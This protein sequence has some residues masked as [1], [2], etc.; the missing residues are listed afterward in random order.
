MNAAPSPA[1]APELPAPAVAI[2][3]P[4]PRRRWKTMLLFAAVFVAGLVCGG[5]AAAVAVLHAIHNGLRHP[6]LRVERAV[7]GLS[8]RLDLDHAQQARV[9]EILR[10]QNRELQG[11]RR[12]VWPRVQTRL[13]RTEDEI[14]RE[15]TPDQR[16][17]WERL[18][19]GLRR[20]WFPPGATGAE[21]PSKN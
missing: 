17:K 8:R 12:E 10:D 20:S 15:L 5:A 16:R 19:A 18:A 9:R 13:D 3:V 7:R 2:P 11:L 21:P 14:G 4:P 6:E 1:A